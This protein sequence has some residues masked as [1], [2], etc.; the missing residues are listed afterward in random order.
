M[1]DTKT[2]G[3]QSEQILIVYSKSRKMDM[4]HS[5]IRGPLFK[6]TQKM[7]SQGIDV[8]RLNT[9]NP[10]TFGF[11][12]PD[13]VRDALL[14]GVDRAVAYCDPQGMPEAR[15]AIR[16]YHEKRGVKDIEIEDIFIGNGV[17][18]LVNMA[19]SALVNDGDEILVPTP[20]YTL[21]SNSIYLAGGKPVYY[22]C[23]EREGWNPDLSD[24]EK[25][26][27]SKTRAIVIIN[28]NNPTGAVYPKEILEG[29][30]TLARKH[31]LILFSDEIY[32]RLV[33]DGVE[34]IPTATL[35][36]DLLCI[37]MNGLSKSHIICGFRCGWMLISGDKK[38]ASDYLSGLYQLAAMRLCSNALT[39]LAIPAAL[40]DEESTKK[41]LI[42]GGRLYEQREAAFREIEKIDGLTCV[43]NKAAFYIFPKIDI[44]RFGIT[45]DK[46]FALDLLHEK[47]ILI[48]PGSG[49][50]YT[51]QAH[52]RVVMLPEPDA[53]AKAIS[54]IGD[55]LH[56][57]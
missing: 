47:H 31:K 17:S 5:D 8:L 37:T 38:S 11:E 10:A 19:I 49:F 50:E 12:M 14:S 39:Q 1:K 25:K 57:K 40:A 34:H 53:L 23:D 21:W 36:P 4:V 52:F 43:K 6:E 15:E 33:M 3:K 28:P 42:P 51:D 45:D 29:I 24:M 16:A 2:F 27:T 55:F 48:V 30:V 56:K 9:G 13:S 18:E 32:D 46:K 20:C 41:L 7:M 54:D 26:I 35:A 22:L 44:R